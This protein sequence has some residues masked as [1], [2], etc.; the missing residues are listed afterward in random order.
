MAQYLNPFT[1]KPLG[2]DDGENGWGQPLNST[3]IQYAFYLNRN[4]KG[5]LASPDLLPVSPNDG[6]AYLVVSN[7]R[8]YYYSKQWYKNI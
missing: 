3:L 1:G 2:W 4:V 6:D 7:A 8:V 5:I